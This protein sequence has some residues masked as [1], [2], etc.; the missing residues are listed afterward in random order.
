MRS[1]PGITIRVAKSTAKFIGK[2]FD[3]V[4]DFRK[5]GKPADVAR[6]LAG[7]GESESA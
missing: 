3:V 6:G 5:G 2:K 4:S 1:E 7:N